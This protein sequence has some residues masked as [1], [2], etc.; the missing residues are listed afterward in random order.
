MDIVTSG[1][2]EQ[3]RGFVR[4]VYWL[5]GDSTGQWEFVSNSGLPKT[6]LAATS[7]VVIGDVNDDDVADIA[8]CSGLIV[9]TGGSDSQ[10]EADIPEHMLFWLG[11]GRSNDGVE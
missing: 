10:R 11:E 9:E 3:A 2:L 6:G 5:R 7:G 8:A 4:G 1:R